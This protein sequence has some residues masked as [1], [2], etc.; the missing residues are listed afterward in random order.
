MGDR[1]LGVRE[2][3]SQQQT[4]TIPTIVPHRTASHLGFS[5]LFSSF[6]SIRLFVIPIAS[7]NYI[8]TKRERDCFQTIGFHPRGNTQGF[9]LLLFFL[10]FFFLVSNH[11][12]DQV[13][14]LNSFFFKRD[15]FLISL[16]SFSFTF[17]PANS[18]TFNLNSRKERKNET[19]GKI[20]TI[21]N[22]LIS[23][24]PPANLCSY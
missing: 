22:S 4:P 14:Y 23:F 12:S 21:S 19:E 13:T 10:F 6:C 15:L 17:F 2:G 7:S 16:S 18:F 1:K 8:L 24:F 5:A 9:P 3:T 11:A 20:Q